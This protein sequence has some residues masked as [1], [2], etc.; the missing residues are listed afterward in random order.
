MKLTKKKRLHFFYAF[1]NYDWDGFDPAIL[2]DQYESLQEKVKIFKISDC[3][4]EID[5]NNSEKLNSHDFSKCIPGETVIN[6]LT[7]EK[8]KFTKDLADCLH[9]PTRLIKRNNKLKT[10]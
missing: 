6:L 9:L 4:L 8:Y 5:N 3:E 7:G 1:T 10:K 2:L